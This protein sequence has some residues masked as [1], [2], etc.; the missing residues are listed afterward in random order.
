[1]YDK[2]ASCAPKFTSMEGAF[3]GE[4]ICNQNTI[5]RSRIVSD[6]TAELK[7]VEMAIWPRK[8]GVLS[9]QEVKVLYGCSRHQ[10]PSTESQATLSKCKTEIFSK[11]CM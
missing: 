1:M 11:L 10:R 7:I 4:D 2:M 6:S 5:P 8:P 9:A 3:Q